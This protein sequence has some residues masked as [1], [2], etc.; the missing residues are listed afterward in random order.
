MEERVELR[1]KTMK[2]LSPSL[3]GPNRADRRRAEGKL[4]RRKERE[5]KELEKHRAG[6]VRAAERERQA[7]KKSKE[8][9]MVRAMNHASEVG[10]RASRGK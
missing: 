7:E 5:H 9:R 1:S 4:A 6:A 3:P 10:R 2:I 8:M